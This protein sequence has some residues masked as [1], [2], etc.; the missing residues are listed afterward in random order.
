MATGPVP[1][2]LRPDSQQLFTVRKLQRK[3]KETSAPHAPLCARD[4]CPNAS[5]EASFGSCSQDCQLEVIENWAKRKASEFAEWYLWKRFGEN[6]EEA[7]F[8]D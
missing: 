4:G 5:T 7:T 8:E 6:L 1:H 3:R 2:A